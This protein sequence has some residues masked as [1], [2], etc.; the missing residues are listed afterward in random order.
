MNDE[1]VIKFNC[2]WIPDLPVPYE[3]VSELDKWRDILYDCRLIGKDGN[4][5]GYGNVS[6]RYDGNKFIITG[7]GTGTIDKMQVS[8]YTRVTT[9]NFIENSLTTV[10]PLRASSES[11]THAAVYE[12]LPQIK[13]VFHVH[14]RSLWR[15]LL[16]RGL[17]TSREALY[18][19]PAMAAEIIRLLKDPVLVR[20]G[21]L[22]MAGHEE[23]VICFGTDEGD[24]GTKLLRSLNLNT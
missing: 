16:D 1:G 6:C 23:G 13:A 9:Y 21:I 19:T 10:G 20:Q 24:T 12:S 5:I 3:M 8:H 7:S 4:G 14:H 15:D 17:C 18:G 22:A 11:L 2:H